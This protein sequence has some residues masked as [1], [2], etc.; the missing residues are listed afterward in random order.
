MTKIEIA[1]MPTA[2]RFK[3]GNRIR[4]DLSNGDSALT[5]FG[6]FQHEYTPNKLGRD[7]IM[8]DAQYPSQI[9]LP[10]SR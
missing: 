4:V 5:E 8:H 3:K 9:L 1:V 2:Y 10:V 7:T 6:F